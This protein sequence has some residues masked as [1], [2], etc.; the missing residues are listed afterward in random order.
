MDLE[1]MRPKS[2]WRTNPNSSN[3]STAYQQNGRRQ[4]EQTGS[5]T[6]AGAPLESLAAAAVEPLKSKALSDMLHLERIVDRVLWRGSLK[7]RDDV[8][9][10]HGRHVA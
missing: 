8:P 6:V 1:R 2:R 9:G 4:C 7:D 3:D 10:D 5:V